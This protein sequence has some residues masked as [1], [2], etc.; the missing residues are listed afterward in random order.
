MEIDFSL[1][2]RPSF[3]RVT[4]SP[5]HRVSQSPRPDA[6]RPSFFR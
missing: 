6:Y 1:S 2:P 4:A 3:L 5:R